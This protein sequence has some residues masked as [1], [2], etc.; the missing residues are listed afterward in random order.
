M[1]EEIKNEYIS[2]REATKYCHYSQEYLSLRA[3]QGK[4]KSVKFGRN[5]VTK[6]DWLEE[7]LKSVEEYKNNLQ[8]NKAIKFAEAL[9]I[10]KVRI[11]ESKIAKKTIFR[12]LNYKARTSFVL[13]IIFVLL[14]TGGIFGK[15]Y[16]QNIFENINSYSY[17]AAINIQ[18][19]I[20]STA[21]MI[22]EYGKWLFSSTKNQL[23]KIGRAH[24]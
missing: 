19:T 18:P 21:D 16:F 22:E 17:S 10:E 13:A 15:N 6:E 14:I 23:S 9:P 4:L 2:L 3:R 1:E 12:F 24:V 5:W 8:N 11:L 7:Y 20:T